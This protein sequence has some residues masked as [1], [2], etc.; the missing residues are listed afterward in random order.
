MKTVNDSII[1]GLKSAK[2]MLDA[3]TADLK[4]SEWDHRAVSGSNCAAW[5][6][7]HLILAERRALG[8]AG[9]TTLPELPAGFETT[10]SREAEAPQAKSFG[11]SSGLMPMFDKHREM[12]M[13]AVSTLP[14]SKFEEP[15]PKP[16]ARF[17]T[18]GEFFVFMGFHVMMH[19]GQ[20]ST[21][22]RSLGRPPLF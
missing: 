18:Y 2:G 4:G 1:Y 8:M 15:L 5:L 12:L 22:R 11:D 21:I 19:A 17:S 6:V 14:A 13:A 20:I 16:N 9:V 7:G 3:L 10:F